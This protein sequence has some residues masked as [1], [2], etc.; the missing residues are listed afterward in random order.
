MNQIQF[1]QKA[2]GKLLKL[3][4]RSGVIYNAQRNFVR[5]LSLKVVKDEFTVG[6]KLHGFVIKEVTDI[7]ELCLTAVRLSHDKT[8]ADYLHV[9]RDDRDNLFSVSF[10]TTP[11]DSTGAAHILE[12]ISLCG[13]H[14]YPCHDPFFKMICRSLSTFL[15]AFTAC[16]YTMYPFSTQ[17]LKDYKNLMSVYLDAVF[18]PR[19]EHLDFLQEG[20]R[21]EHETVDD[22]NS[23]IVF[24]GVVF[25]EMKGVYA[26]AERIFAQGIQNRLLPGHTF[27]N[28]SGGNPLEIP[29]L[30]YEQLKQ[31]HKLHYHPSNARFLT[32]GDFPLAKHLQQ[33]DEQVLS[34]YSK[35]LPKTS[36]P[37]SERWASPKTAIIE[38]QYDPMVPN[39]EKQSTVS[40]NYLLG[41]INDIEEHFAWTI[42]NL[43]LIDGPNSPF[44]KSLVAPNIGSGYSPSTGYNSQTK[45]G[46]F[47]IGLRGIDNADVKRVAEIIDKTLSDVVRSGFPQ[48]RI[49][50]ILHTIELGLKNQTTHFGLSLLMGLMS[51]WNYDSN[52]I[53]FLQIE[54]MIQALRQK[55]K[56]NSN[57]FQEIIDKSLQK[58]SHHLT[59]TMNAVEDF[60]S[61]RKTEENNLLQEKI[62]K[63]LET[64]RQK[65]L[66]D[67]LALRTMQDHIEDIS[68]L[69]TLKLSDIQ[70]KL[71]PTI[72]QHKTI[73]GVQLQLCP[74]PTNGVVY[75]RSIIGT[76]YINNDQKKLLPLLCHVLAR[77]ETE[78]MD[79]GQLAQTIEMRTGGLSVSPH[80]RYDPVNINKFEE[81]IELS[82]YC[83]SQNT[84][85]M[86]DLWT[87]ILNKLVLLDEVRLRTLVTDLTAD[88]AAD[89]SSSGHRYAMIRAAA[90][91]TPVGHLKEQL[92]GLE[93]IKFIKRISEVDDLKVVTEQLQQ[94]AKTILTKKYMRVSLNCMP[95]DVN[96]ACLSLEK[97][98]SSVSGSAESSHFS[99]EISNF[100]MENCRQHLVLPYP[101][102]FVGKCFP[103]V[104]F[105]HHDIASLRVLSTFMTMKFFLREI[106]EKGGAYGGGAIVNPGHFA[107]Y[108]Y[109]DPKSVETLETFDR[110]VDWVLNSKLTQEEVD[111]LKLPVFAEVDQPIAPGSRGANLFVN[112][113]SDEMKQKYRENLF[114]VTL[115]D[116]KETCD[117]YLRSDNCHGDVILGNKSAA[118]FEDESWKMYY[119]N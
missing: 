46:I 34:K 82:S 16:S 18:H 35:I 85:S 92:F 72:T 73:D 86:F 102:N 1:Y 116:L 112:E 64:D 27:A 40:V 93:Q 2:F 110:G 56:Q 11:M 113:I 50:S 10:R 8:G 88:L 19:L 104:T 7:P 95:E 5:N 118:T 24:K 100:R 17:N 111:E 57:Y 22:C 28:D 65:I 39:P 15:N 106:R 53:D 79:Y 52:P 41:S 68:C 97:L 29:Q 51:H 48:E 71:I 12:H 32:Y 90:P 30:T 63:L 117:R 78:T 75:F 80:L 49:E 4:P 3:K 67:G 25:N 115:S 44:Y 98:V 45:E 13:S 99:S 54:R 38:C 58:N 36:I 74:Q 21:L 77:M 61:K 119:Y 20:W 87:E 59:L 55:L 6:K 26:D 91:L 109:R 31:F 107:F 114:K 47:S 9:A 33:I 70:P 81:G 42:L 66:S 69:P 60:E 89:I 105:A 101:V 96:R 23:P 76:Q 94:L 14:K 37:N 103:A 108:S 83:L 84:E 62:S 43:L